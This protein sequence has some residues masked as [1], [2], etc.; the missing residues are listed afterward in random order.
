MNQSNW[1]FNETTTITN[2]F[3]QAHLSL[4]HTNKANQK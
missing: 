3:Q 1:L 4:S 2:A